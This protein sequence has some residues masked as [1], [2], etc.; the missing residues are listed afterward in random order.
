M[1]PAKAWRAFPQEVFRRSTSRCIQNLPSASN[2]N[3][4]LTLSFPDLSMFF[5]CHLQS[6]TS[7]GDELCIYSIYDIQCSDYWQINLVTSSLELVPGI[8]L[9]LCAVADGLMKANRFS[10]VAVN[11]FHWNLS[12][13]PTQPTSSCRNSDWSWFK[14]RMI[15]SVYFWCPLQ[16]TSLYVGRWPLGI[17]IVFHACCPM[18]LGI[19]MDLR[20]ENA[21]CL[22]TGC[23]DC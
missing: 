20:L 1:Y 10:G 5:I 18:V 14:S 16:Q 12:F 3:L 22:N 2:T 15:V 11:P 8:N 7:F 17:G 4:Y 9:P 19:P 13:P 21:E 23:P 6:Y